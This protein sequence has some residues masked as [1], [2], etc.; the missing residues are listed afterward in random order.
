MVTV[1][2]LYR[3][4]KGE[5]QCLE[6]ASPAF[7]AECLCEDILHIS[8][9]QRMI[10]PDT[11]PDEGDRER[12]LDAV[13]RRKNGYPLQYILGRWE[14]CGFPF[15]VGEG[16]LIPRPDTET[17]VEAVYSRMKNRCSKRIA[18]LCSGSGAIAVSLKKLLPSA[19]VFA[20]ELSGDAMPYLTENCRMNEADVKIIRG[21]VCDGRILQNF[22][23]P[24]SPGDFIPLDCIVSNPP[25]ITDRDM[26]TLQKEVTYEPEMALRGGTD[27]LSFYRIITLLWKDLL[28]DNGII[29]FECGYDQADSVAE[30]MSQAGFSN[31]DTVCDRAGIRRVVVGMI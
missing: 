15:K 31:I 13:R 19:E 9:T 16:V 26:K 6:N 18:D 7:E 29:A 10:S 24:D 11:V 25:Y 2:E 12:F 23:D 30:I 17:L 8:Q 4:A 3:F 20:V 22:S 21:D 5:L 27:G 28:S 1:Q 14:F